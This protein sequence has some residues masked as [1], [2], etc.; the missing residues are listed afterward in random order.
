M[1]SPLAKGQIAK[2]RTAED[3][4]DVGETQ[5][6]VDCIGGRSRS[7]QCRTSNS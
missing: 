4:D 6:G 7:A 3:E 5:P 2:R 1:S